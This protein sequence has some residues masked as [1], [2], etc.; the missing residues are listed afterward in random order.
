[1]PRQFWYKCLDYKTLNPCRTVRGVLR[2]GDNPMALQMCVLASG[3]SGNCSVLKTS[4]GSV[5][6]DMGLGPRTTARR[7]A[8]RDMALDEIAAVCLTH[9][10][11]DHCNPSWAATLTRRD[12]CVYCH[13]SCH[14]RLV[15][16]LKQNSPA[17][18]GTARIE[19][20]SGDAFEPIP[21]LL[22]QPIALAH[23]ADGSHGFAMTCGDARAGY[24]TDLGH[25][26]AALADHF[27]GVDLLAI[28]SNY[29]P[30]MQANSGRPWF[31]QQR[32]T[33]SRGHLSNEQAF[34]LVVELFN[35]AARRGGA[36]RGP[37]HVVLLHRSRQCNCPNLLRKLFQRDR[38]IAA[39]LTLSEQHEATA[40]LRAHPAPAPALQMGLPW[41]AAVA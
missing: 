23:D 34:N 20:F 1:M 32:I 37:R 39:V 12:I 19:A 7:L 6:I 22:M 40:W 35:R 31:L 18:Q 26:P 4:R 33:G 41:Q 16:L 28:E 38:R 27:D 21:G 17:A 2:V 11:H 36:G 3:S 8:E 15:E 10:D 30:Q 5:L 13:C 9:L 25:V 29:D 24:A 14:A